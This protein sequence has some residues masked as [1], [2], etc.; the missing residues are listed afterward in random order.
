MRINAPI[1]TLKTTGPLSG[2][3]KA[4]ASK[5]HVHRLLMAAALADRPTVMT[6]LRPYA[7][8]KA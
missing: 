5:S 3:V 1:P 6:L 4:I 2:V 8:F 7:F